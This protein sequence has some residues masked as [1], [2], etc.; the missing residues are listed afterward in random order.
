MDFPISEL[1]DEARCT[2]SS[3]PGSIPTVCAARGAGGR[4]R[5][6]WAST[7]ATAP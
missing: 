4:C 5:T 7:A 3:S 6:A 2:L 1:M